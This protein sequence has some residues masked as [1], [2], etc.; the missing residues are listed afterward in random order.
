MNYIADLHVHSPYSRA[1]S[2]EST[3][4]GLAAWARVK[5]IQLLATGDCTHPGWFARLQE[6]L[7]PAE[8]G[9]FRLKSEGAIPSPLPGVA[10]AAAP[11]RFLL[12][13]EVSSIYKR[14]GATRKVHNL[15]Y[16]PDFASV[17]R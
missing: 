13:V 3:L 11:V 2:K 5:G 6:E 4:M 1:T 17:G 12:S 15:L 7:E 8:P 14:H 9:L 10:P 16:L